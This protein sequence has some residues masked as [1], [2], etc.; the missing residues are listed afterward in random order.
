MKNTPAMQ[1]MPKTQVR[2]LG[3]GGSL[4]EEIVAHS[5]ILAWRIPGQRS[6]KGC[7]PWGCKESDTTE[8]RDEVTGARLK[9]Q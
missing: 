4:E 5:S 7:S 6:L 9:K 1:E 8:Q 2:S 3:Q